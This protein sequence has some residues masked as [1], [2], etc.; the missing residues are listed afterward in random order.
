M[1]QG[2][3]AVPRLWRFVT[4]GPDGDARDHF[5]CAEPAGRCINR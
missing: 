3:G 1:S 2:T 4:D 5:L